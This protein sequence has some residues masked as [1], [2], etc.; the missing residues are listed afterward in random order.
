MKSARGVKTRVRAQGER[1][2]KAD[3]PRQVAASELSG[4]ERLLLAAASEFAMKGFDGASVLDIAKAAGVKQPLL[5]YHFGGKEG[6]WHAVLD[7]ALSGPIDHWVRLYEESE[8]ENPLDKLKRVL[9]I[10]GT[11]VA[12]HPEVHQL[13]FKEVAQAGPRLDWLVSNH[14]RRFHDMLDDAISQCRRQGY[15]RDC[16]QAYASTLMTSMLTSVSSVH[17][18]VQRLY[19]VKRMSAADAERYID[20]VM[21]ILLYGMLVQPLRTATASAGSRSPARATTS[22][23]RQPPSRKRPR[24]P[25]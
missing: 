18:L 13:I 12:R 11:H 20:S 6:L 9:R 7:A 24:K 14:M 22:S 17:P 25:A 4:R 19:G 23:S 16:P 15:L 1:T 3:P 21:D 8:G 5:N 10:F 2:A